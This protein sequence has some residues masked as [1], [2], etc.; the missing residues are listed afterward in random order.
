MKTFA[1]SE[2]EFVPIIDCPVYVFISK[3]HPLAKKS[4][5]SFDELSEYPCLTYDQGKN[6][7]FYFSEEVYSTNRYK[8]VIKAD[9]RATMVEMMIGLNGYTLGSGI[10]VND[11][12]DTRFTAVPFDSDDVMTIG[13][14]HRSDSSLSDLAHRYIDILKGQCS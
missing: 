4:R 10:L 11:I 2:L 5:I 12:S 13:Y 1:E 3:D 9:D 7:A 14:I 6:N 8:Q